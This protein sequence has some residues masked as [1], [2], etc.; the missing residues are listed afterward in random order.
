MPVNNRVLSRPSKRTKWYK[1]YK[2]IDWL[3]WWDDFN[4]SFDGRGQLKYRTVAQFAEAKSKHNE[5]H[6]QLIL[7]IIGPKPSGQEKKK[8]R[9]PWLGDWQCKRRKGSWS[10]DDIDAI[11][12]SHRTT[13]EK[14]SE[15]A[16]ALKDAAHV[17]WGTNYTLGR[18]SQTDR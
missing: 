15:R 12:S 1:Y 10:L 5:L 2:S 13:T 8:L 9:V 17:T 3:E 18:S 4:S 7:E 14:D 11:I 6:K 16:A